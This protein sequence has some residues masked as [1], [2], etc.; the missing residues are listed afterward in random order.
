M[1]GFI[2]DTNNCF[3][4]YWKVVNK[5]VRQ[6]VKVEMANRNVAVKRTSTEQAVVQ[7]KFSFLK[8]SFKVSNSFYN[9][10]A[11]LGEIIITSYSYY[12]SALNSFLQKK[13]ECVTT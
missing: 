10:D 7:L 6:F 12:E 9:C 4:S 1:N 13:L 3:T 8:I 5:N 11:T 2:K